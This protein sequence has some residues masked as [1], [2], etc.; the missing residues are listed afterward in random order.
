LPDNRVDLSRNFAIFLIAAEV[1]FYT[2]AHGMPW[3]G[4]EGVNHKRYSI[5][6]FRFQT[7]GDFDLVQPKFLTLVL[8]PKNV[9]YDCGFSTP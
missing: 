8:L 9:H 2:A 1:H 3:T 5:I 6:F 4:L 7:S